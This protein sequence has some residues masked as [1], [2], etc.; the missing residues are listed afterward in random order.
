MSEQNRLKI[1]IVED[2]FINAEILKGFL[3]EYKNLDF[4]KNADNAM[5]LIE[6]KKYDLILMDINLGKGLDGIELTKLIKK[7]VYYEN[8][9]IVAMTGCFVDDERDELIGYGFSQFLFKP[10]D[11]EELKKIV[12]GVSI[13]FN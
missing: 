13:I 6:E 9:P 3:T 7:N 4:A 5:L 2:N 10:F 1:L 12:S 8:V 11:R